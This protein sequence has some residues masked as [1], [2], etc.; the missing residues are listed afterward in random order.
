MPRGGVLEHDRS[1][2]GEGSEAAVDVVIGTAPVVS[3]T[4]LDGRVATCLIMPGID[5]QVDVSVSP[6]TALL[7]IRQAAEQ[8]SVPRTQAEA[9]TRRALDAAVAA[10]GA[11]APGRAIGDDDLAARL[12]GAAFPLLGAAYDEGATAI[13]E[14]PRWAA[15]ILSASTARDGAR[16]AF[17][18]AATRP[19][20]TAFARSLARTEGEPVDLSRLALAL[21]ASDV[22]QSDRLARILVLDGQPWPVP[23]LP[24]PHA[25]DDGR[26]ATARWGAEHTERYLTESC[27][28]DDGFAVLVR[29]IRYAVDLGAHG[30]SRLPTHLSEVHDL[31]RS[32]FA[33][34]PTE[35]RVARRPRAT[36]TCAAAEP[37]A[38]GEPQRPQPRPANRP[39]DYG[40]R[41][42]PAAPSNMQV[43]PRDRIPHP[44]WLRTIDGVTF[45]EFRLVLPGTCGD[46]E[47]WSRMLSN[48]L[49]TYGRAARS[50]RSHLIGVEHRDHLRYVVE[51]TPQRRIRQFAGRSNRAPSI[52]HHDRIAAFL[53]QHQIVR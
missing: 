50:G 45:D 5:R 43:A 9:I 27:N 41:L 46:L 33:T 38:Q 13:D 47:L 14:V 22:L 6:R 16:I 2:R 3:F 7:T 28:L 31:Y 40:L 29:C 53:T 49:D 34:L 42:A 36:R 21:I 19:V 20:V 17:G 4:P 15:P 44:T 25:L 11:W 1:R 35:P 18:S 32:R 37:T 26:R 10:A 8:R 23:R 51:V 52:G 24:D 12:G 48:C 39:P 30:P